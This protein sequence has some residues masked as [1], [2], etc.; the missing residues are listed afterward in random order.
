M[1]IASA[2]KVI[3]VGEKTATVDFDGN[4]IEARHGLVDVKPGDLVL[5][6]AGIIIQ[7]LKESDYEAMREIE[8]AVFSARGTEQ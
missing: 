5:V 3:K 4:R 2:G 8:E 7:T 6:H 1:C